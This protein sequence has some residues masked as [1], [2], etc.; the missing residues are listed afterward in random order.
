MAQEEGGNLGNE[1]MAAWLTRRYGDGNKK[2][3]PLD[4]DWRVR[5]C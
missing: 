1:S 3:S 4:P 2:P 5:G